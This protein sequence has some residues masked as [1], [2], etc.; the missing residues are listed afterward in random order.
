MDR[1]AMLKALYSEIGLLIE[2][3]RAVK[4]RLERAV[5][6]DDDARPTEATK[7]RFKDCLE[8]VRHHLMFNWERMGRF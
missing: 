3:D 6:A 7:Q 2:Y 8:V 4:A 1:R 5:L